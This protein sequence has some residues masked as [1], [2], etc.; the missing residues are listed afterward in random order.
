MRDL[1]I[2]ISKNPKDDFKIYNDKKIY[3]PPVIKSII[4]VVCCGGLS[5]KRKNALTIN[6]SPLPSG[7]K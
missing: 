3:K 5:N 2:L 4:A 6:N 1:K 7:L